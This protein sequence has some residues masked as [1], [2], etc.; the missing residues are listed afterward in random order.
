M[1]L[2]IIRSD[3]ADSSL[4]GFAL[5]TNALINDSDP[6][7]EIL[8]L[9]RRKVIIINSAFRSVLENLLK[10]NEFCNARKGK[11]A[12]AQVADVSLDSI[13]PMI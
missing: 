5:A 4:S 6:G 7:G 11:V 9:R 2:R 12:V 10:R 13:Q 8:R 1:I 3:W